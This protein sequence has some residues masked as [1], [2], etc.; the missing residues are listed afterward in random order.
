M[1]CRIL[2]RRVVALL[3]VLAMGG[4]YSLP[5]WAGPACPHAHPAAHARPPA[6]H[7][8]QPASEISLRNADRPCKCDEHADMTLA[9][10]VAFAIGLGLPAGAQALIAHPAKPEFPSMAVP[11]RAGTAPERDPYPP[12]PLPLG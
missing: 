6:K 3:I 1:R 5:A 10:C 8:A 12:K 4:G 7:H 2:F 9:E 11:I